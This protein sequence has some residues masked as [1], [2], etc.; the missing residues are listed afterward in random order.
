MLINVTQTYTFLNGL[1][2]VQ[3]EFGERATCREGA[4]TKPPEILAAGAG[5]Q[6]R[7]PHAAAAAAGLTCGQWQLSVQPFNLCIP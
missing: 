7:A 5:Q 6:R 4:E 1:T 3:G 2:C